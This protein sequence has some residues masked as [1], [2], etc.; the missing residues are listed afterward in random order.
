VYPCAERPASDLPYDFLVAAEYGL[1]FFVV[2]KAFSSMH[3]GVQGVE[4]IHELVCFLDAD[5]VRRGRQSQSPCILFLFDA[6]TDHGRYLR[7]DTLP[8]TD[9]ETQQLPV[10]LPK[11]QLIS[12]DNLERF[13]AGLQR[14]PAA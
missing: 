10:H 12:R 2:A 9:P 6:D 5:L 4:T 11:E 7:L 8:D 13:I 14:A 3:L 1:C